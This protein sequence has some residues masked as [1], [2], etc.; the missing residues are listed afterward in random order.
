MR[1]VAVAVIHNTGL[2]TVMIPQLF[3]LG[4]GMDEVGFAS[5]LGRARELFTKVSPKVVIAHKDLPPEGQGIDELMQLVRSL[6]DGEF[7]RVEFASGEFFQDKVS[8]TAL[9]LGA[10]F[11][12]DPTARGITAGAFP[13]WVI[14]TIQLGYMYP[15]ELPL[16]HQELVLDERT[17]AARIRLLESRPVDKERG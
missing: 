3:E 15:Q 6:P 16:R 7:I 14:D 12:W 1:D 8:R 9:E 11:G 17:S 10:D 4:F 5:S 13:N 2:G